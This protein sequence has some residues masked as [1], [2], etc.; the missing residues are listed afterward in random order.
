[1]NSLKA[2]FD[3]HIP[4][5]EYSMTSE[6]YRNILLKNSL[7][8]TGVPI[9]S[10]QLGYMFSYGLG[11]IET[12]YSFNNFG[13]R[14]SH[15]N[16]KAEILAV[17]CSNT[18]GIG[19]PIDSRWT[20]ILEQKIHKK[21]HNLSLPG[22]SIN[23]LVSKS[24]EYF[25]EFGNPHTMLCLFP[26]PFRLRLPFKKKLIK[27]SQYGPSVDLFINNAYFANSL[28]DSERMQYF[29]MPYSYEEVLPIELPLYFSMQSIHMLEQYCKS[30][31]IKL[32]WS[33]WY[34]NFVNVLD[35]TKENIFNS[36]FSNKDLNI[37]TGHY[38]LDK[39]YQN[40]HKDYKDKFEKYFYHGAD[41]EGGL[42][43]AH[44]GVH[45]HAHIAETFYSEINK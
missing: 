14:D 27:G 40:C 10:T 16:S 33:S 12:E 21:I 36:F 4:N 29:K 37:G 30:N 44:P 39:Q 2:M 26:D 15:W 5:K 43:L 7:T 31:N 3:S 24:F 6:E 8:P 34:C 41:I 28:K 42:N 35:K 17:G 13:Y 25:K 18:Y 11:D 19:V 1:M 45:R 38:Y 32:I 22:G 9:S 23:E 20:N